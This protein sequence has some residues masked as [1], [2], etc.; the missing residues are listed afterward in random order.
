MD[1]KGRLSRKPIWRTIEVLK[2]FRDTIQLQPIK[3]V[4]PIATSAVREA[5]NREEFLDEVYKETGF[6]FKVLS[7]REEALYSYVGAIKSRVA[8]VAAPS[9]AS[10]NCGAFRQRSQL[11]LSSR[12]G[13]G[14]RW[15]E[16]DGGVYTAIFIGKNATR[17][18]ICGVEEQ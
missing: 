5:S 14:S 15:G 7:E 1:D 11:R 4:L 8:A 17:R 6:R 13:G 18:R 9:I 10:N 12:L 16:N 3:S 2:L